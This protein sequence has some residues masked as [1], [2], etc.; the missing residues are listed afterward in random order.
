MVRHFP[1]A[2]NAVLA[3]PLAEQGQGMAATGLARRLALTRR[4]RRRNVFSD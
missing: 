3:P 1:G 4:A 2:R